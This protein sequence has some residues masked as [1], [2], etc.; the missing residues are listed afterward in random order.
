[1]PLFSGIH[2]RGVTMRRAT[3]KAN[4]YGRFS[5]SNPTQR[6]DNSRAKTAELRPAV[7]R[8]QAA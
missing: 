4:K 1:M 5:A 2:A 6:G 3:V 8:E 7:V